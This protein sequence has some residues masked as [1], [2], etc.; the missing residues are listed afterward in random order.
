MSDAL[1][2][3]PRFD[4][5]YALLIGVSEYQDHETRGFSEVPA[6]VHN[7][8]ALQSLLA[9][10]NGAGLPRE[11]CRMVSNPRTGEG[12]RSAIKRA[13]ETATDVLLLYYVG[14]GWKIEGDLYLAAQSSSPDSIETTGLAYRTV[15]RL[16]RSSPAAIRVI[17][18]DCCFSGVATGLL[19]GGSELHLSASEVEI[20]PAEPVVGRQADGVCVIA[21][22]GPNQPSRDSDGADYTAFT[23]HL[24][25]ALKAAQK[26]GALS[27]LEAVFEETKAAMKAA[28]LPHAPLIASLGGARRLVLVKGMDRSDPTCADEAVI[29]PAQDAAEGTASTVSSAAEEGPAKLMSWQ[30][31]VGS[32]DIYDP[33][34][35]LRVL[36]EA[37]AKG[38]GIGS[39]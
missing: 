31:P 13:A 4:A 7:L 32:V 21:S 12:M 20:A 8:A 39:S 1:A 27:D 26:S 33:V 24:L 6:A 15:R 34:L 2:R 16:V 35:A 29:R 25:A 18:L 30:T 9:P 19:S 28:D 38:G 22:S 14:H 23:G 3:F 10:A 36:Q 17:I 11:K 37:M 5:S